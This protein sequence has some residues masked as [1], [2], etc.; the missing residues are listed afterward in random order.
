[1][2]KLLIPLALAA[3]GASA[4]TAP[5]NAVRSVVALGETKADLQDMAGKLNP[6]L[7]FW[8][9]LGA[10]YIN[11]LLGATEALCLSCDGKKNRTQ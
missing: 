6:V 10:Y 5:D 9:P 11:F 3:T 4:F 2:T 1:M 8:D 7:K